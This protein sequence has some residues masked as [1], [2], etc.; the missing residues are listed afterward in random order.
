MLICIEGIDG[1]G[2]STLAK[3]LKSPLEEK[4]YEVV[5]SKEPG[6]SVL[7]KHLRELLQMQ[8]VPI[9]SISEFLLYASDRAQH[10]TEIVK[11]ALL[12]GAIVITDRMADSSLVYQGYG[13]GINK[14]R[15]RMVNEW[16][17]QGIKPSLTL[18]V[19]IDSETSTQRLK[20]RKNLSVFDKEKKEFVE[21]LI[22]GFNELY[23]NRKD[24]I[25]LD[26]T[27]PPEQLSSEAR[28]AIDQWLTLHKQ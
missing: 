13:R 4:G 19:A 5:L 27:L 21:R 20:N 23:E 9:N 15:I 28:K 22:Q 16:A 2:K 24:V 8:P 1:S 18:Y 26:G 12:R 6:G 7:G 14:E 25:T 11:P 17:L 3:T 10:I